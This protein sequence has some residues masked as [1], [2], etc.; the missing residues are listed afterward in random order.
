MA[1][2]APLAALLGIE[3][4]GLIDRLRTSAVALAITALFGVIAIVFLLVAANVALTDWVGPIYAP[5][6]I[7]GIALVLALIVWF[8]TR[9]AEQRRQRLVAE[10]RRSTDTTALITTAAVTALPLIVR[11][12]AM[13]AIA[14]PAGAAL[15]Y[16]MLKR[17]G[18]A[19]KEVDRGR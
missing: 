11:N 2:L 10:K 4:D 17:Q 8:A 3:L 14:I 12:P 13:R 7:A 18:E 9:A 19:K 15:A 5:L 6:I 1:F 16:F